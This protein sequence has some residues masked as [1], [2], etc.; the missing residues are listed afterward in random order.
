MCLSTC[1][2]A[3]RSSVI[4]PSDP[5]A[6]FFSG[7]VQCLQQPHLQPQAQDHRPVPGPEV[8]PDHGHPVAEDPHAALRDGAHTQ[9]GTRYHSMP[10]HHTHTDTLP[11][12]AF[13]C[14]DTSVHLSTTTH[15]CAPTHATFPCA[16]THMQRTPVCA[17]TCNVPLCT[18][19]HT[20]THSL[21]TLSKECETTQ[22]VCECVC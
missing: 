10:P 6:S 12:M 3:L 11:H 16:R 20:H 14:L 17:H 22:A 13:M 2:P 8:Q 7:H 19:T 9:A 18:H 4:T 21:C 5:C 1:A 15:P